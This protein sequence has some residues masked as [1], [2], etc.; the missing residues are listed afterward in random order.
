LTSRGDIWDEKLEADKTWNNFKIHFA[1]AYRQHRQMQ[2]E[3]IGS[4]AFANATVTQASEDDLAEQTIGAFAN[5]ATATAVDRNV[6]AQLTEASSRLAKQLEDNA[7][8]LKEVKSLLKKNVQNAPAA[9]TLIAPLVDHSLPPPI[10]IVGH[11]VTK[12]HLLTQAKLACILRRDT[13]VKQPT[14]T[15]W[16]DLKS[17]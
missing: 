11:M 4:Q 15:S 3:T 10:N 5:L 13:N 1:A 9:G 12:W 14:P 17:I 2:G 6:V 8:Y 7:T 16:V